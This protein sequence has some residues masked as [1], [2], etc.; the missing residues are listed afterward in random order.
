MYY[1]DLSTYKY[2]KLDNKITIK[3]QLND[4]YSFYNIGWLSVDYSYV[5][6]STKSDFHEKLFS[7]DGRSLL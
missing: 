4:N 6:G 3:H 5:K 1:A 2:A 7:H